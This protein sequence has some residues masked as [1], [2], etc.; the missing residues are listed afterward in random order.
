MTLFKRLAN[1]ANKLDKLGH[2]EESSEVDNILKHI[3]SFWEN[4]LPKC[5]CGCEECTYAKDLP[6]RSV[7]LT[8][9]KNCSTGGCEVKKVLE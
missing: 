9:H 2:V 4:K 8:H 6:G 5:T 7:A 1:L 3:I